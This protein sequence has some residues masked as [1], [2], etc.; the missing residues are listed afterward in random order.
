MV[1]K[2]D[3]SRPRATAERLIA[4]FGRDAAL[5][6]RTP[7]TP[8]T[9]DPWNPGSETGGTVVD[10]PAKA[11]I[12][13]YTQRERDGTRIQAEDRRALISTEG[14]AEVDPE[15]ADE[16]VL[17]GKPYAIVAMLALEP[18]GTVVMYDAQVRA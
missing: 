7:G 14:L 13:D 11:A 18:G 2:F 8:G 4:R 16:L 12:V 1:A 10:Y 5:R 3:Y 17:D 15:A 9:G 6:V